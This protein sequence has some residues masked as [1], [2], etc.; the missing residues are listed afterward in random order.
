MVKIVRDQGQLGAV[1]L[2][3][4]L[5]S[6]SLESC[7][8]HSDYHI[9][10]DQKRDQCSDKEHNPEHEHV[11]RVAVRVIICQHKITN[12]QS[13]R[14]YEASEEAT[15]AFIMAFPRIL[16]YDPEEERLSQYYETQH[17]R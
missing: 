11:A 6:Y 5:G 7:G 12:C 15:Q 9:Q 2:R 16:V 4:C 8:H 10:N 1:N 17:A 3:L 14:V 13:I